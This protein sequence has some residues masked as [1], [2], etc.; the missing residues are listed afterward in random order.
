MYLGVVPGIVGHAG[1]N[2]VLKYMSPLMVS[3]AVQFEPVI[4]PF[5]G[6]LAG[7]AAAPGTFTWIGGGI[8]LLATAGAIVATAKRQQAEA[9]MVK[10]KF[11]QLLTQD[12]N[13]QG[14]ERGMLRWAQT[15]TMLDGKQDDSI[16][17]GVSVCDDSLGGLCDSATNG[18]VPE[19]NLL[20][21]KANR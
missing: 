5:L 13:V 2:T 9:G 15:G 20:L 11:M 14:G 16:E 8:V 12:N 10:H 7:V 6:W 21:P 18:F 17:L 3:L 4:G 1:F 19:S